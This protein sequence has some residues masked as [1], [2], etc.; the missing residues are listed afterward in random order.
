MKIAQSSLVL[1]SAQFRASS[2]SVR[3][4]LQAW[5]G[6]RPTSATGPTNAPS[7]AS[8]AST[9][10]SGALGANAPRDSQWPTLSGSIFGPRAMAWGLPLASLESALRASAPP[11]PAPGVTLPQAAPST[12]ASTA[13]EDSVEDAVEADP[14]LLTL[15][16]MIESITGQ[17]VRTLRLSDLQG[18]HQPPSQVNTPS[19]TTANA[20]TPAAGNETH[21]GLVYER[22]EVRTEVQ[23]LQIRAQG[24]V[25]T[26]DGRTLSIS[27]DL[28]MQSTR[29]ESSQTRV[30]AGNANVVLK[31][32]LVIHFDGPLGQLTNS[33]FEFDLDADGQTEAMPFVGAGSGFVALD[34]NGN[35]QI[36]D[37]RELFGAQSGDGFA[38]LAQWDD[39]GNGWIDAG[40]AV[41]SRLQ[42]WRMGAE[43]QPTL[44]SLA[45]TDVAALYLGKVA[46]EFAL[47]DET[48]AGL[49]ASQLGQL[50]STGLYLTHAGQ[51][52]ALQQIDL[53]V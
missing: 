40:D 26:T 24:T 29:T 38:D 39:D 45:S 35:G 4:R 12:H 2:V 16:R 41:F 1:D 34:R 17:T 21:W 10:P 32:P 8:A 6:D 15:V 47:R 13:L 9:P 48:T 18:S 51:A 27:L 5:V 30:A 11:R 14:R 50:R 46:S 53:V 22:E 28:S 19:A 44:T 23:Q 49:S 42:V 7:N 3:E 37:G 25:H 43:G 33:R 31:D 20:P 52:G 36:D